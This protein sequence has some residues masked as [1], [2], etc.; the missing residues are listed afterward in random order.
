MSI[1]ARPT[2]STIESGAAF[3]GRLR[4]WVEHSRSPARSRSLDELVCRIALLTPYLEPCYRTTEAASF[5]R[6]SA[7]LDPR[8]EPGHRIREGLGML[9]GWFYRW[10]QRL[11]GLA[12]RPKAAEVVSLVEGLDQ[13]LFLTGLFGAE[14]AEHVGAGTRGDVGHGAL[15]SLVGRYNQ[16]LSDYERVWTSRPDHLRGL[17]TWPTLPAEPY[18]ERIGAPESDRQH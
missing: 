6:V 10:R 17:D 3:S 14:L 5:P 2:K 16:F 4:E 1:S 18:Y 8:L 12:E 15:S 11:T 13:I 9:S 7:A